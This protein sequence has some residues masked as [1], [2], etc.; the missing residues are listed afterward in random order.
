MLQQGHFF[1]RQPTQQG[2]GDAHAIDQ[3]RNRGHI[4]GTHS[5]LG[6]FGQIVFDH[7]PGLYALAIAQPCLQMKENLFASAI[8]LYETK[9]FIG[10]PSRDL[11]LMLCQD[12]P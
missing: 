1:L 6:V 7:L 2:G 3:S 11:S 10:L 12:A 8:G 5:A 9:A 4:D